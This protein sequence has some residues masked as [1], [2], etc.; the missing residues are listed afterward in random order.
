MS[1]LIAKFHDS[2][3]AVYCSNSYMAITTLTV[4]VVEACDMHCYFLSRY[5]LRRLPPL[6]QN[7]TILSHISAYRSLPIHTHTIN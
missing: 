5:H 7:Q 1:S 3:H 2:C 4:G 6:K